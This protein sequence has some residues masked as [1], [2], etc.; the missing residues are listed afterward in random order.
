VTTGSGAPMSA[1]PPADTAQA[2]EEFEASVAERQADLD[3]GI[4]R[5]GLKGDPYRHVMEAYRDALG[6]L[7]MLARLLGRPPSP[8]SDVQW[9]ELRRE[10]RS[11]VVPVQ[12]LRL[13][14]YVA[15]PLL[16]FG[17]GY[18]VGRAAPVSTPFGEW[19]ADLVAAVRATDMPASWEVCQDQPPR[20]GRAWCKMPIWRASPL[21]PSR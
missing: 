10:L 3:R 8:I 21:P 6:I 11:M 7:P 13:A 18:W 9:N 4:E 1:L 14:L 20:Q 19:P 16:V 5:A 2:I 17:L 12:R 15:V